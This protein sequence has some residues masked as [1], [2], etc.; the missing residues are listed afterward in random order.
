MIS[1]TG[2]GVRS[3]MAGDGGFRAKRGA[4]IHRGIDFLCEPG[5]AVVSPISGIAIRS[6]RPYAA[7]KYYSGI[8]LG[9]ATVQVKL[10]YILPLTG[11]I[12]QRVEKGEVI[13]IA[14]DISD[15]YGKESGMKPHVHM[16]VR[17]A[18]VMTVLSG[19]EVIVDPKLFL[20]EEEI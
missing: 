8:V 3:D 14:Q 6:A 17:L 7:D 16:E 4:D 19:R 20:E 9:N 5:Q 1:P 2:L 12:G 11:I 18:P 15:K 10:F 13:G